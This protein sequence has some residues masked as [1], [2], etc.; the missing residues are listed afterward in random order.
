MGFCDLTSVNQE[1]EE[2]ATAD[3]IKHNPT[4]VLAEQMLAFMIRPIILYL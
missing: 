3:E 2:I 4:L 1:F